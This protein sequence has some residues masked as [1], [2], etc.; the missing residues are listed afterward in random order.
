MDAGG[1][2]A[3][4]RRCLFAGFGESHRSDLPTPR[5][6]QLVHEGVQ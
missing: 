2:E 5:L 3:W 6:W 1:G 4:A